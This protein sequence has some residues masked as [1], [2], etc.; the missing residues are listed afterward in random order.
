VSTLVIEAVPFDHPV[1]RGLVTDLDADLDVRYADD[2]E[3][4]E[5]EPDRAMLN[6]LDASV[7]PPL[8]TFLVAWLDGEAVGCGGLR[9]APTGEHGVAE[10][11]RMY[12]TPVARGQGVSRALLA[13]LEGAA[14]DLGYRRVIL[15]TGTRQQEAMALY[16][17]AGY[18]PIASYG[19]Y[20]Y[21]ELSRCFGKDLG[22][23]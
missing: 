11:K 6:V 21:S 7:S 8:G 1:V 3:E 13:G 22:I 17:S 18:E 23:A 12:V 15:E 14:A 20:R 10:I 4:E 19:A 9:P 5:G 16:E 2:D